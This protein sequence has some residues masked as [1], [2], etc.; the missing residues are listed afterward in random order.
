MQL[1]GGKLLLS[2]TESIHTLVESSALKYTFCAINKKIKKKNRTITN[3][4]FFFF[5]MDKPKQLCSCLY[6]VPHA[7]IY[8]FNENFDQTQNRNHKACMSLISIELWSRL[9]CWPSIRLCLVTIPPVAE[10]SLT[11]LNLAK[12]FRNSCTEVGIEKETNKSFL[13]IHVSV[14]DN[15]SSRYKN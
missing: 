5:W 8:S 4:F 10:I 2:H 14:Y 9:I 1:P 12:T 13:S 15:H 7:R 3:K 6:P 11:A